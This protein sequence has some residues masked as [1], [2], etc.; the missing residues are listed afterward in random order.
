MS[1]IVCYAIGY[2]G[3]L[4]WYSG[5]RYARV[6]DRMGGGSSFVFTSAIW[7]GLIFSLPLFGL[8]SILN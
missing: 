5:S 3:A 2:I 8:Y 1:F 7:G 6:R 4:G